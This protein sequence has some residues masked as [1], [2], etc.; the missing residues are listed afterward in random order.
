MTR[1]ATRRWL[2]L[3]EATDAAKPPV[4]ARPFYFA[5]WNNQLSAI[6]SSAWRFS[7][8]NRRRMR[9]RQGEVGRDPG[10]LSRARGASRLHFFG[11][12]VLNIYHSINQP[13]I[14]PAVFI[15][16]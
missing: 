13:G 5:F 14:A 8:G 7:E 9:R 12:S 16:R 3:V 2:E 1:E 15:A 4:Y 6:P 11:P 10:R